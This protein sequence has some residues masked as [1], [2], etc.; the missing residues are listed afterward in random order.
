VRRWA[1]V[2][3]V[4]ACGSGRSSPAPSPRDPVTP[5]AVDAAS[6]ITSPI[7][8]SSADAGA[9]VDQPPL[10][11]AQL[12][13][14]RKKYRVALERGRKLEQAG[15]HAGAI[16]AFEEA[17]AVRPD[18]PKTLSELGWAA[19]HAGAFD[20]AEDATRKAI[21]HA[22]TAQQKAAALYNLGRIQEAHGDKEAARASY[23]E[24]LRLRPSR[25]VRKQLA[26]LDSAGPPADVVAASPLSGPFAAP[27]DW[28]ARQNKLNPAYPVTC[29]AT[30]GVATGPSSI[31]TPPAPYKEVKLFA[32]ADEY[33]DQSCAL[34]IRTAAGW[35]VEDAT[36][37]RESS[38]AGKLTAS[39]TTLAIVD[40]PP[41][42][43]PPV[44]RAELLVSQPNREETES[45]A[46]EITERKW[47]SCQLMLIVCRA[48]VGAK[49]P[50]VCTPTIPV[51]AAATCD[52]DSAAPKWDAQLTSTFRDDGL[53]V[54]SAA[55]DATIADDDLKNAIGSYSLH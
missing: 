43:A 40:A 17:L 34:A 2:V 22:S 18:D 50:P 7:P 27:E 51:A 28:C 13:E 30:A 26:Q 29:L 53:L 46:G 19:F 44:L 16:S 32:T 9:R 47:Q 49:D 33:G 4:A 6:T 39:T 54:I 37:C 24:S 42:K 21:A 25:T 31:E 23:R 55:A 5:H 3:I 10:T 36:P 48:G 8:E 14:A 41:A 11:P 45:A 35:F 38:D 15:D 12:K 52:D 1:F 20:R